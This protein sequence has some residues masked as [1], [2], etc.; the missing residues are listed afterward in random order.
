M[1]LM[2][3]RPTSSTSSPAPPVQEARLQAAGSIVELRLPLEAPLRVRRGAGG[4]SDPSHALTKD[5]E[6][7]LASPDPRPQ[8][9]AYHDMPYA[10]F[11][12]AP[13]RSSRSARSSTCWTR[14]SSRQGKRVTRISLAE[15]LDEAMTSVRAARGLVRGR[16]RPGH[17]DRRRDHPRR[18][19]R[20]R[21]ARSTS[22]PSACPTTRTRCA[23]SS[24]SAAPA[25]CSRSTAPSRCSSS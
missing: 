9:S 21:P 15:C 16:A 2:R 18:P 7:I 17:R 5:L 8:I 13:R 6:P 1:Y 10:L 24:S 4:M 12:Y 11:H 14:A 20:A 22:S 23:T 3:R 19:R 25:R